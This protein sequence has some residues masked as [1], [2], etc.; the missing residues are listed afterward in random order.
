MT[1]KTSVRTAPWKKTENKDTADML[2]RHL[3]VAQAEVQLRHLAA[4]WFADQHP[5]D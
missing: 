5:K 1:F 3:D 4:L 2:A